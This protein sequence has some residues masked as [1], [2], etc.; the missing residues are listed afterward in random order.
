MGVEDRLNSR[1]DQMLGTYGVFEEGDRYGS[2]FGGKVEVG[3]EKG[4]DELK[5]ELKGLI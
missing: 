3:W 5:E 1:A 4:L 2:D